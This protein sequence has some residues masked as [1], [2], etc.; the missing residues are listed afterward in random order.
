[1][2]IIRQLLTESVLLSLLGGGLGLLFAFIGIRLLRLLGPETLPRISEI[3]LDRGVLLF[4]F[5]ISVLTG[6]FFGLA[7]ALRSARVD[8][9]GV[10]KDGGRGSA[11]R[12]K[13]GN[14]RHRLKDL[15]VIAELLCPGPAGRRR[16]L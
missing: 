3:K 13:F 15:L 11:G 16:M 14:S 2:R 4:T 10:L 5:L 1:M 6:I 8:L 9:N 12:D 7:P